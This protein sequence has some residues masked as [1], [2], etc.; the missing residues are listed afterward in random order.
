[1]NSADESSA[2]G[3]LTDHISVGVL[4]RVISREVVDE[5][6]VETG[7]KEQRVR[8]LP[9]HVVVYFVVSLAVF[10]DGYEEVMRRLV[11]GLRLMRVW[12]DEW[13][14]PSTSA[15]SQARERLGEEPLKMLFER[16]AVPLAKLS[17]PGAWLRS[18]RL[19]AIDG[20]NI[21]VPDTAENLTVFEKARGGTRRPFPQIRSVGLAE[22]GTHAVVAAT[23]GTIRDG[24]RELAGRLL[25]SVEPDMLI[26]A[27]RGFFSFELWADFM[28]TGAALLWRVSA[29]MKLPPEAV[30]ADGSYLSTITSKKNR[31]SSWRIPL[32]AVDDPRDASHIPVRVIEYTVATGDGTSS[33][34][35]R[36]V[37]TILDP[38]DATALELAAVYQQRWEYELSLKEIETQ[39]LAPG[40]GLRSKSPKMVR[41]EFWGLL[42][43]HY[44]IRALMVEA[45]DTDGIDPDRLSFQRTLNIVRRQITDQAAFSPLDTRAGDHQSHRRDP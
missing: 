40:A 41:Q 25:G 45:A 24:E 21:D 18:W 44:A 1:M 42:L 8:R 6:L 15:L 2:A 33:E 36:L 26:T 16:V 38:A 39:L 31:G 13:T 12:R 37:T 28:V 29:H 27:D 34:T 4:A 14:V 9:A 3:R 30:L 32:A 23:T 5:V 17:T 19:M 10:R 20:V 35:F 22:C 11:G 7:K 43:A